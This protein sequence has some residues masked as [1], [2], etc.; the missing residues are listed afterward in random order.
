MVSM[1]MNTYDLIN[2]I[3]SAFTNFVKREDEND[4]QLTSS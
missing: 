1:E 2:M 4:A 3:S